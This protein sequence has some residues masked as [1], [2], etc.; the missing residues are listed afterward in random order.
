MLRNPPTAAGRERL[1]ILTEDM[2]HYR[3]ASAMEYL[4]RY[5]SRIE[6][7][8]LLADL[9]DALI[10][11]MVTMCANETEK[12]GVWLL[13]SIGAAPVA[14]HVANDGRE[15]HIIPEG[16][17][18]SETLRAACGAEIAADGSVAF[19]GD[20][21]AA[22]GRP[23]T[24]PTVI[25][26][27]VT[28]A[29]SSPGRC[30]R[31]VEHAEAYPDCDPLADD[32]VDVYADLAWDRAGKIMRALM[33]RFLRLLNERRDSDLSPRIVARDEEVHLDHLGEFAATRGWDRIV[34]DWIVE[35]GNLA[36]IIGR[37]HMNRIARS[38]AEKHRV[39]EQ[40]AELEISR[41]LDER[42]T[43]GIV[44]RLNENHMVRTST[45]AGDPEAV[46]RKF[47]TDLRQHLY[48]MYAAESRA[49]QPRHWELE[50][51]F[52]TMQ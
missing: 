52:E 44:A 13:K 33:P 31:C 1:R 34:R 20:W 39:S 12:S 15:L 43:A 10:E 23:E 27:R 51:F 4:I 21:D 48:S 14:M 41:H 38:Y 35:R 7:T 19:E 47:A 9:Q 50:S 5:H 25:G 29:A 37:G 22:P 2:R 49:P 30:Q 40:E 18:S 45:R 11:I 6:Q 16:V 32:D 36:T 24:G 3:T 42:M 17:L 28:I 46:A 26:G 8:P